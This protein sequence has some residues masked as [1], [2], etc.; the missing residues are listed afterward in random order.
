MALLG[1]GPYRKTLALRA[2]GVFPSWDRLAFAVRKDSGIISLE[3]IKEKKCPLS[4]STRAGG[5]FHTTL[6]VIDEVLRAYGFSFA[7]IQKWGGKILRAASPSDP[8]RAQHIK[9]GEVD[10]VFDEGIKSWGDLALD[11]DMRFLPVRKEVLRRM[12]RL[13]FAG[14]SLTRDAFP[15]LEEEIAT[16]DFS[17]W[18]F[19]CNRKLAP[20]LAYDMAKAIDLS[21]KEVAADHLNRTTMTMQEF[22]RGGDGGPLTIPLHSGA[23]RYYREKGYL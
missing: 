17:G 18:V 19:F 10:A 11:S 16:V 1:V 5:K 7:D 2:I 23:K 9:S 4:V 6:Y 14:A 8:A 22:C 3:Q 13:G 20:R 12:E 21:H 15:N